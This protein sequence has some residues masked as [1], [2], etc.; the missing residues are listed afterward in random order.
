MKVDYEYLKQLLEAFEEV[1]K[2]FP[3]IGEISQISSSVNNQFAF[4]MGI[5]HDQGFIQY[6]FSNGR[7]PFTPD[8]DD[9]DDF[10][11]C[12]CNVRLTAQGHDF[13]AALRQKN[14]WKAVKEDLKENSIE[15]VWKVAQAMATK[16]ATS[17]L[18][19]YLDTTDVK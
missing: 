8:Y 10:S 4:H 15:T 7:S 6:L 19:K 13:L 18:E 3:L 16:L 5:L 11:W 17:K 1:P 12:D 9:I 2:P 14:I